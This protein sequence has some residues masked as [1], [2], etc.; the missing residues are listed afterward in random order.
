[1]AWLEEVLLLGSCERIILL[2]TERASDR[3]AN[4]MRFAYFMLEYR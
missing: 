4:D 1:M 3:S 2:D